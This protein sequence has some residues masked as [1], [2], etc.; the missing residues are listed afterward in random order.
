V[1][2][3]EEGVSRKYKNATQLRGYLNGLSDPKAEQ[4]GMATFWSRTVRENARAIVDALT[5]E[6]EHIP[7]GLIRLLTK[8][9]DI[10]DGID[11]DEL[12]AALEEGEST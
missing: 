7:P 2:L 4:K 9:K 10:P 12:R 3:K 6:E 8:S 1:P 11:L 5:M